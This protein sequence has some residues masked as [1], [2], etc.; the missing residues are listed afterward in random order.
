MKEIA[1]SASC[2][3]KWCNDVSAS[4]MPSMTASDA[5]VLPKFIPAD[6]Y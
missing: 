5:C 2:I 3:K 6:Q 1:P 4:F